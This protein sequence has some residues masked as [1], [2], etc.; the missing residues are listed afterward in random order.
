M[1][2][3]SLTAHKS[4]V[5]QSLE[6]VFGLSRNGLDSSHES[7]PSG[8]LWKDVIAQWHH[9]L[10]QN[11]LSFRTVFFA[12]IVPL[13]LLTS[14]AVLGV[15]LENLVI[16]RDVLRN[17]VPS[18]GE[19]ERVIPRKTLFQ[20]RP[21]FG[22][23]N[24]KNEEQVL[25]L[26]EGGCSAGGNQTDSPHLDQVERL[27]AFVLTGVEFLGKFDQFLLRIGVRFDQIRNLEEKTLYFLLDGNPQ[28]QVPLVGFQHTLDFLLADT[29][30]KL[31]DQ[32]LAHSCVE[33]Y[34]LLRFDLLGIHP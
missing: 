25:H 30:S 29:E 6:P 28:L 13:Q 9:L 11:G 24:L 18:A 4:S 1:N 23:I 20:G 16:Q 22:E 34:F 3:E 21:N 27:V 8:D 15:L 5:S 32:I 14:L 12:H 33:D 17:G 19:A 7:V 10:N 26:G 31:A 2:L